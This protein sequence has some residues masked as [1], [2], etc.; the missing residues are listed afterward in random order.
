MLKDDQR[1]KKEK[2]KRDEWLVGHSPFGTGLQWRV[3]WMHKSGICF[4]V[5]NL[6]GL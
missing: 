2:R 3:P 5:E 1:Q 6:L 4:H